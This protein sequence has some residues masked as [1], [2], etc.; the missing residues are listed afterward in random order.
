MLHIPHD[1]K[2]SELCKNIMMLQSGTDSSEDSTC[3]SISSGSH[4]SFS[5]SSSYNDRNSYGNSITRANS[6]GATASSQTQTMLRTDICEPE[7][8]RSVDGRDSPNLREPVGGT[9]SAD[10]L[11]KPHLVSESL[12]REIAAIPARIPP[13]NAW[14]DKDCEAAK[15]LY[16]TERKQS[17][18]ESDSVIDI[19]IKRTALRLA[20]RTYHGVINA[21]KVAF[22]IAQRTKVVSYWCAQSP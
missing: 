10:L 14:W 12:R 8:P 15:K 20:A 11:A 18:N 3:H 22:S 1:F 5:T 13:G 7:Q 16:A 17:L 9:I 21:R 2:V 19:Q 6:D 4:G